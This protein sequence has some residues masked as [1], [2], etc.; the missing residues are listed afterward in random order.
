YRT[1]RAE[2]AAPMARLEAPYPRRRKQRWTGCADTI[3][4]CRSRWTPRR[5]SMSIWP[6]PTISRW[7]SPHFATAWIARRGFSGSINRASSGLRRI[8]NIL[9]NG[10][11]NCWGNRPA[12]QSQLSR[13]LSFIDQ[14]DITTV[15]L[16]QDEVKSFRSDRVIGQLLVKHF[17]GEI[18]KA[19]AES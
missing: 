17:V 2:E 8:G 10:L 6:D 7:V 16:S 9:M 15:H 4:H 1:G 19:S 13:R 11:R 5:C 3:F 12:F 14:T 18:A